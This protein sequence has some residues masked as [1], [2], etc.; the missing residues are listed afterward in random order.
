MSFKAHT[1]H[2]TVIFLFK[3][4]PNNIYNIVLSNTVNVHNIAHIQRFIASN[5]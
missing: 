1:N 4:L 5:P 3:I 2:S